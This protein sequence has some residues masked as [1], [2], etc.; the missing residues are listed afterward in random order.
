METVIAEEGR[1]KERAGLWPALSS[2]L[3]GPPYGV[4]LLIRVDQLPSAARAPGPWLAPPHVPSRLS[5]VPP[6]KNGPP[7]LT[8]VQGWAMYSLAIQT[9]LPST[10]AAP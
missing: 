3:V 4:N 7:Q 2:L 9:E 5:P 1:G 10:A 8:Y 6:A